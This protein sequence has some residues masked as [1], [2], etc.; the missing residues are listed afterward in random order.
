[1]CPLSVSCDLHV[2]LVPH[3]MQ[4]FASFAN[5]T[6]HVQIGSN[7][8]DSSIG[9]AHDGQKRK[10]SWVFLPQLHISGL[11]DFSVIGFSTAVVH[12][13]HAFHFSSS[14]ALHSLQ[15]FFVV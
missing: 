1:M 10:S 9:F 15:N 7:F 5:K 8:Q 4:N 11:T 12:I 6:P 2:I 3:P 14:A 13:G